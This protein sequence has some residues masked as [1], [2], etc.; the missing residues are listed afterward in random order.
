MLLPKQSKERSTLLSLAP[1]AAFILCLLLP[2]SGDAQPIKVGVI[3]AL[4][5]PVA[6]AGTSVKNGVLLADSLKDSQDRVEF[7]FEDDQFSAKNAVA[8]AEKL[9]SREG[10]S[11]LITFSG[12]VSLP[13]A[14]LAERRKIPMIAVTSF[15]KVS[16]A[17]QFVYTIFVPISQQNTLLARAI[18]SKGLSRAAVV[19]S[20]QDTMLE[21]RNAFLATHG[22]KV[23]FQEEIAPGE[24]SLHSIATRILAHKP[25][26]VYQL[27]LPPQ[28]SHL[29]KLL[30]EQ[31][32]RGVIVGGP[33]MFN[34][35]EFAASRGGL[36]GAL[37]P[38]PQRNLAGEIFT[39]YSERF[40]QPCMSEGL[41][42]F[43]AASLLISLAGTPSLKEAFETSKRFEGTYGV[44][45]ISSERLIEVPGELLEFTELGDAASAQ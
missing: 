22:N 18:D 33:P 3:S 45:P 27:T 39:R 17:K 1:F 14:H 15:S 4:S 35:I 7:I 42:A 28:T 31:G 25:D 36:K 40:H 41:Y 13:V 37:F 9:I 24:T 21:L 16:V 2:D 38:G 30:R 8:A 32:F 34:P 10:V 44:Y 29:A 12:T 23:V 11:A 26:V 43:E 19:T 20:Q 5:G 6:E